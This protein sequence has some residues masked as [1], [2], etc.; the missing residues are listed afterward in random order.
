MQQMQTDLNSLIKRNMNNLRNSVRLIGHLGADPEVK[1]LKEGK[2]MS[3][4]NIATSN[5]YKD[6]KGNKITDTQCH[7]VVA[8]DHTAEFVEKYLKKGM[9]IAL[10]GRLVSRNYDNK[11]G[12]KQYITEVVLNEVTML[13]KKAA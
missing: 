1:D 13:G 2:K 8:W 12:E 9:E 11:E 4:F 3:K 6:D 5:S 7:H 10:E